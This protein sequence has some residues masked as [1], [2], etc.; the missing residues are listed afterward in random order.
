MSILP[1]QRPMSMQ[2]AVATAVVYLALGGY[3]AYRGYTEHKNFFYVIAAVAVVAA[4]I[5]ILRTRKAAGVSSTASAP[6]QDKKVDLFSKPK[7]F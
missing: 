5:R 6:P 3:V 4:V 2:Y 1:Q 7:D